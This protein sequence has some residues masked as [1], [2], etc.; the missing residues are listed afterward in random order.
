M[1]LIVGTPVVDPEGNRGGS[2]GTTARS[3]LSACGV[4]MT[5]LTD[6][7]GI[8]VQGAHRDTEPCLVGFTQG[9]N[10]CR[11][12]KVLE[13]YYFRDNGVGWRWCLGT[14]GMNAVGPMSAAAFEHILPYADVVGLKR[15]GLDRGRSDVFCDLFHEGLDHAVGVRGQKMHV[16]LHGALVRTAVLALESD[17]GCNEWVGKT[18]CHGAI[19]VLSLHRQTVIEETHID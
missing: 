8:V 10:I 15:A 5:T 3:V 11:H 14:N 19:R 18:L 6:V 9:T 13:G 4:D 16:E 7:G 2:S 17:R 1:G 12:E